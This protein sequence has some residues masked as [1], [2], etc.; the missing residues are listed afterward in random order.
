M[1]MQHIAPD[2]VQSVFVLHVCGTIIVGSPPGGHGCGAAGTTAGGAG[3][4][5]GPGAIGGSTG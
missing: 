3:G 4:G 2:F 5:G 1:V